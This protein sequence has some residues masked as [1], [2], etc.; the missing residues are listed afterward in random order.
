MA[1]RA[2][3]GPEPGAR[4]GTRARTGIGLGAAQGTVTGWTT[5]GTLVGSSSVAWEVSAGVI[6]ST[7]FGTLLG[8]NVQIGAVP[9]GA[10]T[11]NWN[12]CA[13]G[14]KPRAWSLLKPSWPVSTTL[15]P[16]VTAEATESNGMLRAAVAAL[17]VLR[18]GHPTDDHRLVFRVVQLVGL[19]DARRG[20]YVH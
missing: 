7:A 3:R 9:P 17:R 19:G 6:T 2:G 13:V 14:W 16:R 10:H 15:K 4:T 18:D 1:F 12:S 8:G 11:P 20:E 5:T